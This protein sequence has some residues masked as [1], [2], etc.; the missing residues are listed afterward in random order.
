[1]YPRQSIIEVF[2]AFLKFDADKFGGWVTDPG[3]RRSMQ[4]NLARL[5]QSQTDEHFW[6]LYWYKL[7]Q[8]QP[9][10][11]QGHLSAYLQE[12]CY[13]ATQQTITRFPTTQY[14]LAD[15]FQ[16]AMMRIAKVLKGFNPQ[17]GFSLSNY[18]RAIFSSVLKDTL[19]QQQE[20]DICTNWSLLRKLSQ[21]RLVESLQN[22]G[23]GSETI[24]CYLLAW[25]C[26]KTIYIPLQ[27]NGT[28]KLPKP[29]RATWERITGV[30][31]P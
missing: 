13:W 10:M 7:W 6:V 12:A 26:F 5:P 30:A 19:R 16:M 8:T 31:K 11:A 9:A 18:A 14:T 23:L 22:A 25:N 1:M 4:L 29:E 28:R 20:A 21:K 15:C 27:P 2:S 17:L 24:A 3:L